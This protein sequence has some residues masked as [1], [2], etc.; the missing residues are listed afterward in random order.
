MNTELSAYPPTHP[1]EADL[2][3]GH[4]Y[5]LGWN[6]R[7]PGQPTVS[8]SHSGAFR[9]GAGTCLRFDPLSGFGIAVL[10]NG[11]P[12]GVPEAL[13]TLFFN[14][15]YGSEVP[16]GGDAAGLFAIFRPLMMN[17]IYAQKVDNYHR[18]ARRGT[19]HLPSG[20]PLDNRVFE[21]FSAY[22]GSNVI[23]ERETS[24]TL[25]LKL[26]NATKGGP[27][28]ELPLRCIDADRLTFVYETRGENEVGPSSI[29]LVPQNGTIVTIINEWLNSSG[30]GLGEIA[31][32]PR[33][34]PS[35]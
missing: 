30:P 22:Y 26:G 31:A 35:A 28:W 11:E 14:E 33:V 27:L 34:Q 21:G 29:Q 6:V 5:S 1:P 15:L 4:H 17:T 8:F 20:V 16:H 7:N 3:G 19:I 12:T 2:E 18:F 13:V 9:L 32:R 23:V 10:S 24:N 25:V